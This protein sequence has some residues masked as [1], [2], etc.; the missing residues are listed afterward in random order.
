MKHLDNNLNIDN[1]QELKY[2]NLKLWT[3]K[4]QTAEY[5][6]HRKITRNMDMYMLKDCAMNCGKSTKKT[7]NQRLFKA[8]FLTFWWV[9]AASLLLIMEDVFLSCLPHSCLQSQIKT[10]IYHLLFM[11]MVSM[12]K[13]MAPFWIPKQLLWLWR[14]TVQEPAAHQHEPLLLVGQ[15]HSLVAKHCT[16]HMLLGSWGLF[17][18]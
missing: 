3:Y 11:L 7:I 13:Y 1:K 14:E 17:L 18:E 12:Q 4:T 2:L 9:L 8:D 6:R 10:Y 16:W 15:N 5:K